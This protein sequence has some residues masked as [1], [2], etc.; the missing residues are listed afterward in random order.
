VT[1]DPAWVALSLLDFVGTKKLRALAAFFDGDLQAALDADAATLRQVPGIGPKIAASIGAVNLDAVSAA[2]PR[3]QA[4]GVHMLTLHDAGYPA[5][6]R[7]LD[8]APPTLF[9][10]GE[11]REL[12]AVAVVGTR[13][14]SREAADAARQ[15]GFE[16]AQ[17]GYQVISGL[18]LGVDSAAHI[19][20]LAQPAGWTT[21]VLGSGILN[22]YPPGNWQLAQA[23]QQRGGLLSEVHPAA[24]PK[25]AT[26]VARNR[27]IS[28]LCE[29]L[30]VVQTEI[31]GGAM[32]AAQRAGEQARAVYVLENQASGNLALIEAGAAV[33]T[34]GLDG[35]DDQR[36]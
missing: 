12:R 31:D 26:L 19:G 36:K 34:L 4:A 17:R 24:K 23:I 25:P 9:V 3:W 16:L 7:R 27:I 22:I 28:G 32:H 8:D 10:L 33:I 13:S 2:I 29:A 30:I 14:P 35:F 11:W 20:A 5:A 18:A 1:V 15:L 6:L 21:A